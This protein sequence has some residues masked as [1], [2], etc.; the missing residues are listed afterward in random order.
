MGKHKKKVV[1]EIRVIQDK[2]D[3]DEKTALDKAETIATIL[4]GTA[5]VIAL[6]K[7]LFN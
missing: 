1:I 5:S 7:V 3:N 6:I 2:N 4:G